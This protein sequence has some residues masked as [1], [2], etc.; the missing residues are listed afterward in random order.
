LRCGGSI[1]F[2]ADSWRSLIG[3][4]RILI[5]FIP[6]ETIMAKDEKSSE[7]M[8]AMVMQGAEQARKAMEN[9]LNF[10]QKSISA[11]PWLES[12]LNKKMKSYTEQNVAAASEFGRKL[13]QAKDF[14]DLWR[15]QIEFMQTQLQT[16]SEQAKDLG[17]TATKAATGA[18][19]DISS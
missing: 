2:K 19:K 5:Q 7:N 4:L 6:R 18:F 3:R 10:F 15:I 13:T 14:Q 12:D 1:P 17:E 9:Y 16:F 11:S 8:S